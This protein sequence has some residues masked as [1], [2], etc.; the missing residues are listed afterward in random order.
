MRPILLLSLSS[1]GSVA[2]RAVHGSPLSGLKRY[3]AV[4]AARGADGRMHPSVPF[5][6]AAGALLFSGCS[7][8]RTTLGLIDE[9]S[10][11]EELL[12]G[13]AKGEIR[14]AIRATENSILVVHG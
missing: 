3:F 7:A 1:N 4:F 6:I 9:A 5:A 8:V 12:L 2:I 11:G 13:C 10:A 14:A